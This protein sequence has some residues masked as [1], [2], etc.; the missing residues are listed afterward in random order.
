M[1][2]Y[3]CWFGVIGALLNICIY[4]HLAYSYETEGYGLH[5]VICEITILT[6]ILCAVFCYTK[7]RS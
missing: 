2:K 7:A 4:G 5:P 6:M 3:L 1:L